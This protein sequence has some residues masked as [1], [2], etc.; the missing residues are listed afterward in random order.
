VLD[1][2]GVAALFAAWARVW[3]FETDGQ[4]VIA[5]DG[6]TV[7]GAKNGPGGARRLVAVLTHD[8]L[9]D[10]LVVHWFTVV[11]HRLG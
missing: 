10:L 7:W 5:V 8:S 6:K 4:R 9:A 1:A 3:W 2:P 11:V